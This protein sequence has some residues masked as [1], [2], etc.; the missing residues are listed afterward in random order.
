MK[1]ANPIFLFFLLFSILLASNSYAQYNWC[2]EY[3]KNNSLANAVE[4]PEGFRRISLPEDSFENWLRHLPVK[5]G[6][7]TVYLYNKKPKP[8]Q[9]AHFAIIDIDVGNRDLQQCADIIIRLIS[10]YLFYKERFSDIAFNFTSGDRAEYSRW[11]KGYRP[12][13]S[14]NNVR[15]ERSAGE[16]NSYKNLKSYLDIVFIYAGTYSLQK[17]LN[18]VDNMEDM[19]IGDIFIQGGFPGHA[20]IV[21]DMAE[22]IKTGEKIFLIAQS[23]TPAQDFHILKNYNDEAIA[24]WYRTDFGDMLYTPEWTFD[25][26]SLMRFKF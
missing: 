20:V 24:P 1:K 2:N 26:A 4:S 21:L 3:H 17:E 11:T 12:V 6:E 18:K 10:E 13:V 5:E 25:R 16:D 22:N 9:K 8:N 23:Y 14:G 7:T 19:K 15:W